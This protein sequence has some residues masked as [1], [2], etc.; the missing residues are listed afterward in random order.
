MVDGIWGFGRVD[1]L[2]CVTTSTGSNSSRIIF[3]VTKLQ[4]PHAEGIGPCR[5]EHG[6]TFYKAN[7]TNHILNQT[8][9]SCIPTYTI[10]PMLLEIDAAGNLLQM[11]SALDGSSTENV[12]LFD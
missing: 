11:K 7:I 10:K 8:I 1:S 9:L 4:Q 3:T 2:D 6:D 12:Q 5:G